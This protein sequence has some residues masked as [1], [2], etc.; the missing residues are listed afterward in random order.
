MKLEEL[1]GEV[2]ELD[3]KLVELLCRRVELAREILRV[4]EELGA[5]VEDGEREGQVLKAWK[6]RAGKRLE[7]SFVEDLA[8][9]V[10]S[11]CRAVQERG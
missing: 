5:G 7:G 3:G 10:I 1:R 6:E 9:R 8:R 11:Y 4:K 2:D